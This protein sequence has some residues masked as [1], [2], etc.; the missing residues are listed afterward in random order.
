MAHPTIPLVESLLAWADAQPDRAALIT[1]ASTTRWAELARMIR[2][3]AVRLLRAGLQHGD[4]VLLSGPND[5]ELVAAYFAVHAAGCVATVVDADI[6][7]PMACWIVENS[8]ARM[9][10]TTRDLSLPVPTEDLHEFLALGDRQL[11]T[12][13]H[14]RMDDDADLL[15]T[16]GTTGPKKGVLLGQR[17]IAQAALNVNAVLR[18][19]PGDVELVPIPLSHSF[20]LGRLRCMAQSG[21][22]LALETG[23]RN[24]TKSL[25]RLLDLKATG[26][27]L[28][29]AGFQLIL[30]MTGDH[31]AQ[32]RDHLGYVEI[33]SA[34]MPMATKLKLMELLPRTRLCHHY[35]LT[36]ASRASFI[37]YHA[38]PHKLATI[39]RPSP[40]VEIE[41]HDSHDRPT[42]AGQRGEIVVRGGMV[43][44]EY[45][46]QPDLTRK[47]VH[48]GWLRT[49]DWGFQDADGYFHLV[50]R[51]T[52][53]V[54]VSGLKVCPEEVEQH[55]NTHPAIVESACLG[56]PDP[57]GITGEC[58]MACLVTRSHVTD[59]ELVEW[60]RARL[61]E[62][63]IPRVWQRVDRITKTSSGKIQRHLMRDAAGPP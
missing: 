56:I 16:T 6:P 18:S 58:V 55:L 54:N 4:R 41:I 21:H 17:Q 43:M 19:Q 46:R 31:L 10:L 47:A 63:K 25:K 15:Y 45:W 37:E 3:A 8:Q 36:E 29:P 38:E 24:A 33:G 42:P 23:M 20:G 9:A 59:E 2:A 13:L 7:G 49:G 26:L 39:G 61:E 50:G 11:A 14:C 30:R 32:A 60:L 27:A 22:T 48:N 44:K 28:V 12:S 5:P 1:E 53:L 34:P 62:F 51:H 52:D 40:N 57:H 35:G